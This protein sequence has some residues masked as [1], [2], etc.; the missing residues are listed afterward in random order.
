[1]AR[2]AAALTLEVTDHN[3]WHAVIAAIRIEIL[4]AED[5]V[6]EQFMQ[7]GVLPKIVSALQVDIAEIVE[8]A[9]WILINLSAV[10]S[11]AVSAMRTMGVVY[12]LT[13]MAQ[14]CTKSSIKIN[15]GELFVLRS[16]TKKNM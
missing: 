3:Y 10:G 2:L 1:M 7:L 6:I 8:E 4:Q 14:H 13:D 5:S 15:V 11:A 12:T 16:V 9:S